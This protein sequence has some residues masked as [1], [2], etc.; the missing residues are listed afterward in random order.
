MARAR[1]APLVRWARLRD[2]GCPTH[3]IGL[4]QIGV[5]E[6]KGPVS[7]CPRRD[8]DFAVY[9][10]ERK[11]EDALPSQSRLIKMRAGWGKR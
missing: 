11:H 2:G 10:L 1:Q 5:D 7:A 9:H 3:G 4:A 8:C 6:H